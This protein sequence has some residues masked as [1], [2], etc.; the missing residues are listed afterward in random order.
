MTAQRVAVLVAVAEDPASHH[1]RDRHRGPR[2][3]RRDLPPSGLRRARRAHRRPASSAASSPRARPPAT[4]TASATTTTTSSAAPAAGPSTSTARSARFRASPRPTT[5][6]TRS[7]RPRSSTGAAAPTASRRPLRPRLIHATTRPREMEDTVSESENP[8]IDAPEPK[9]HRP[10]SNRDW[11]PDQL[12]LTVLAPQRAAPGS[13]S[14]WT[15]TT[16]AEFAPARR[17]RA[18]GATSKR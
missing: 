16:R 8:A 7:T 13:R 11:W 6:A 14:A 17:R 18:A 9:A 3:A 10:R 15:S 4:R 1:R 12:D 5:R 2:R